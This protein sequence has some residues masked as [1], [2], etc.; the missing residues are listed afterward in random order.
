MNHL[1]MSILS[2][3]CAFWL[4]QFCFS[5]WTPVPL[6]HI[7]GCIILYICVFGHPIILKSLQFTNHIRMD[8]SIIFPIFP[9]I[10]TLIHWTGTNQYL[11]TN[12]WQWHLHLHQQSYHQLPSP[13]QSTGGS[14]SGIWAAIVLLRP[15]SSSRWP[16]TTLCKKHCLLRFGSL[17]FQHK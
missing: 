17:C 3:Y 13:Q 10:A 4:G 6:E 11:H 1:R 8:N 2:I 14:I 16:F 12:P 9:T 15:S 7:C 5:S